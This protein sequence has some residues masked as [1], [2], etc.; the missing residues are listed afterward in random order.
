MKIL[1]LAENY[2]KKDGTVFLHYIHSRN[3]VYAQ[4]NIEVNVLS[5]RATDNYE[6][7]GIKVYSEFGMKEIMNKIKFD[8]VLSHAPNLKNH[9]RFLR[10]NYDI[11]EHIIFYFHGHEV[12]R[13]SKIYPKPYPYVENKLTF[14]KGIQEIYDSLKLKVWKY[15]IPKFAN[16]S[17]FIFVSNWMYDRFLEFVKI[18]PNLIEKYK[19]IIYNCVGSEF[20]KSSYDTKIDKIYDFIT[21]RNSLDGSKYGIDIV[22]EIAKNNP[23]FRFCVVGKGDFFKY[24]EKA[25]NVMWVDKNL[26]HSEVI[27]YLNKSRYAL[28]P[29]RADAQGVIACEVATFGIPLITSD[30]AVCKEVFHEFNNVLFIDNKNTNL[31][32]KL[33]ISKL[34]DNLEVI[35]NEKY[36]AKNTVVREIELFNEVVFKNGSKI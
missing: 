9:L 14:K 6:I 1:V 26:S 20:E 23:N 31:D 15:Q 34:N 11:F 25:E 19:H 10:K 36:F 29:T 12:L 30:L 5:F 3:L 18:D 7:D 16:K 8:I 27:T 21:I 4:H 22:N 32:I 28:L 33:L 35:K 2:T 24:F 17:H 13:K